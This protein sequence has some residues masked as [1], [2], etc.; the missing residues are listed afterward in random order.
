MKN[1]LQPW[2]LF[3]FACGMG[4]L[5]WGVWYYRYGD[6]D[7]GVSVL[8]GSLTYLTAPYAAQVIFYRKW[9]R[10]P[11]AVL[12]WLVTVDMSYYLYHS[13]LGNDMLRWENFVASTCLYWLCGFIWLYEGSLKS[14]WE[15]LHKS[16]SRTF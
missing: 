5:L 13:L 15:V 6:W 12:A 8:M 7:I 10:L 1:Y 14:L 9:K 11:F 2:K 3:T 4:W 16:V